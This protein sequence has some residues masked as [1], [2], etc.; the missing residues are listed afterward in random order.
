MNLYDAVSR[1]DRLIRVDAG[2]AAATAMKLPGGS[3]RMVLLEEGSS[4]VIQGAHE[5]TAL[6]SFPKAPG[7]TA[8][9]NLGARLEVWLESEGM[10]HLLFSGAGDSVQAVGLT[11]PAPVPLAFDLRLVTAGGGVG[12]AVGPVFNARVRLLPMLAGRGVEVGPGPNPAVL[13]SETRDVSYVERMPMEQW[14]RTY[15]KGQMDS[16]K[17]GLWDRYVVDSAHQLDGFADSSLD[18]IFSNHVIEHLVNPL[19]VFRN[20]WAKLAPGGMVAGVIPDA[21]YTFDLRQPLTTAQE[22]L[23]QSEAGVFEPSDEMYERWCRYT[24]PGNTPES[25]R[26]RD[27]SIHVNYFSADHFHVFLDLLGREHELA[28]TFIESTSNGKDFGFLVVKS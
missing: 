3:Q 17:A 19:G 11:W 5:V 26:E 6:R 24:S 2:Q 7:W 1:G 20:W 23:T 13:P 9:L 16:D 4:V 21:R 12:I 25:L 10:R 27:Y 28:G 15:A 14:A 18:F 8:H 22:L